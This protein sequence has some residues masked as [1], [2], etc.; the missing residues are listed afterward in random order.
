MNNYMVESGITKQY[1]ANHTD[2][3]IS[4]VGR[5]LNNKANSPAYEDL[6]KIAKCLGPDLSFFESENYQSPFQ[7]PN[8][9]TKVSYSISCDDNDTYECAEA[10]AQLAI[11]LI[12]GFEAYNFDHA[13]LSLE[14]GGVQ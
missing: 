6:K 13:S 3:E 9:E 1:V 10:F 12:K 5:I 14:E 7:V 2:L 11:N 4:K 8:T